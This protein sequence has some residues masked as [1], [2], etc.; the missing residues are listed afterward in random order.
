MVTQMEYD[1]Y[2]DVDDAVEKYAKQT[3][4]MTHEERVESIIISEEIPREAAEI[5]AREDEYEHEYMLRE[6]H[7]TTIETI[8]RLVLLYVKG[9]ITATECYDHIKTEVENYDNISND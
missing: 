6:H 9:M 5:E 4:S 2:D 3:G 7:E 1:E 8:V